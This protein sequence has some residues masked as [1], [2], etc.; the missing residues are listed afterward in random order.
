MP[1]AAGPR[2][3]G[4][5]FFKKPSALVEQVREPFPNPR[6]AG[7]PGG[8]AGQQPFVR[9]VTITGPYGGS[10]VTQTP[11]RERVFT[12]RPADTAAE[13]SCAHRILSGL[14]RRAYRRPVTADEMQVLLDF[15]AQGRRD[16]SFDDGVELAIRRLLVSPR[17]PLP[18][19]VRSGARGAGQAVPRSR[20][21]ARLAAVVL[22]VEQH[23]GRRAAGR[24]RG[25]PAERPGR[26]GAPGAADGGRPA[27]GN[28]DH[29]LRRAVAA[30]P[31]PGDDG[32]AGRSVL[33]RLRRVA[34]PEHAA[35]DRAL[36]RP[37]RA[38]RPRPGR[39]ADRR[40]HVPQRTARRAL[41]DPGRDR[42]PFPAGRP[43]PPTGTGAAS[44][45]TAASSP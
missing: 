42:Q 30:A 40:L 29:Q 23:P 33:G 17:V 21:G 18:H 19:R 31:Q 15:Y 8:L 43:C 28:A 7:N 27:L 13:A 9:S 44:W 2:E 3:V 6:V 39:A 14:A 1:V 5:T 41:R 38:R 37:H 24:R 36:R 45:D 32:A 26:A 25:R 22:P 10:G 20:P 16:G 35:R 34:A 12:C 11:S 4:V